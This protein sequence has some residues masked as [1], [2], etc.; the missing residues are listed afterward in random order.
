MEWNWNTQSRRSSIL[1][2][3]STEE[4]PHPLIGRP[5]SRRVKQ[6]RQPTVNSPVSLAVVELLLQTVK[7]ILQWP[8]SRWPTR[9]QQLLAE[10]I[11]PLASLYA[12]TLVWCTNIR[13]ILH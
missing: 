11:Q 5:G 4:H 10:A 3:D 6:L 1:Q 2:N 13:V 12:E 8:H 9:H 7:V